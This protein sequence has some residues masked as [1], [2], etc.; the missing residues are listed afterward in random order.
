M[1]GEYVSALHIEAER[2]RSKGLSMWHNELIWYSV[3][4]LSVCAALCEAFGTAAAPFF[5]LQS[6]TATLLFESVSYLEH[7][8]LERRI[9]GDA[10]QTQGKVGLLK[11]RYEPVTNM[12][13]WDT[14]ARITNTLL[15]KLQQH[16]DHHANAGKRF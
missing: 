7:Y 14:A 2:L 4:S 10:D 5:V 15:F 16:A 12:H 1:G 3:I 9:V 11:K 13:S 6:C 8:G